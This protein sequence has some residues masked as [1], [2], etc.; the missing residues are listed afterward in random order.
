MSHT[1]IMLAAGIALLIIL[2]LT[3]RDSGGATQRFLWLWLVVSIINL[4][5]GVFYAGYGWGAEVVVWLLVF[6]APA[7]MALV[8]ARR[9][10]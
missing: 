3:M 10:R 9:A 1:A 7:A 4:L 8:T 6:G 2:R 5:F